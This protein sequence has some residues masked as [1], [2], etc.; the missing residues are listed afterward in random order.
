ME[1]NETQD[2]AEVENETTSTSND[3]AK[4]IE[5]DT[6]PMK[7]SNVFDYTLHITLHKKGN[8]ISKIQHK[9]P[10][11]KVG[12]DSPTQLFR[13]MPNHMD[14]PYKCELCQQVLKTKAKF[15]MHC[16]YHRRERQI[17]LYLRAKTQICEYCSRQFVDDRLF[18]EHRIRCQEGN[19][20]KIQCKIC[21]RNYTS[22]TGLRCHMVSAHSRKDT[23]WCKRCRKEFETREELI[24]HSKIHVCL[25]PDCGHQFKSRSGLDSHLLIH[26]NERPHKCESCNKQFRRRYE[27]TEHVKVHT[28]K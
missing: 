5:C 1:E 15:S 7:F 10:Q 14:P 9:C 16:V 24:E 2:M 22:V 27:L 19:L 25:C 6:C 3:I 13:H 8:R 26:R 4:T 23:I 12:F 17:P 21:S 28:G 20:R 18:T 11:C